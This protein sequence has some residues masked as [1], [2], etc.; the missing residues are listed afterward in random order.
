[1]SQVK[2]G[3][4]PLCNSKQRRA[5]ASL[6]T[7]YGVTV[8]VGILNDEYEVSRPKCFPEAV[9][10]SP[11]NVRNYAKA[12]GVELDGRG[13]QPSFSE[14]EAKAVAGLVRKCGT[15]SR[16][17]EV[18]AAEKGAD[19]KARKAAGFSEARKVSLPVVCRAAAEH[20]VEL[21]RGRRKAA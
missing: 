19:A 16:A 12:A 7:T 13:R 8:T 14:D 9:E 3:R 15:A 4:K 18:L 6:V 5:I 2:R 11:Q 1:M 20:G 17:Q 21:S 10:V